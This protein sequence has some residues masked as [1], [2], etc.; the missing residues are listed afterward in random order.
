MKTAD[1][2]E[3]RYNYEKKRLTIEGLDGSKVSYAGNIA[4]KKF[5]ELNKT[6]KNGKN[7]R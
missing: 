4:V 7:G 2:K 1:I 3:V 5:N 6:D